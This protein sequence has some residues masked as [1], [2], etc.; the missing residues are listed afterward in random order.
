MSTGTRT[1]AL[2]AV[3]ARNL[4]GL[5]EGCDITRSAW[6]AMP[7]LIQAVR[8]SGDEALADAL[9]AELVKRSVT[10]VYKPLVA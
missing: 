3:A 5:R 8:N 7:S 2:V 9:A 10:A 1:P 4:Q 6:D